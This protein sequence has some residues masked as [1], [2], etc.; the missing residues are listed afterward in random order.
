MK[1]CPQCGFH[2]ND[3]CNFCQNCGTRMQPC[4]KQE[5]LPDN[6]LPPTV[7]LIQSE[8]VSKEEQADNANNL[9]SKRKS[10]ILFSVI[11]RLIC[12]VAIIALI[13]IAV[14]SAVN[15]TAHRYDKVI[16]RGIEAANE[17]NNIFKTYTED[18]STSQATMGEK[19]ALRSAKEYLNAIPFSFTGLIEQLKYN[20]Y[21]DSEAKYG[22]DNCG[23]DWKEQAAKSA[24][25]YLEVMSF[26][27]SG[28]IEQL[29]YDGY[30]QAEA[31]YGVAQAGY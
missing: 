30:T 18:N 31:E 8:P 22:A 13:G 5:T 1:Y 17:E 15:A 19:N 26:S 24:K 2:G 6:N 25:Q 3:L 11:W 21:S 20:G 14:K 16:D 9:H 27:R 28:L 7:E 23:A 12:G 10:G 29:L 4:V